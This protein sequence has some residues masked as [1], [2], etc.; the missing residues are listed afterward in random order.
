MPSIILSIKNVPVSF[1]MHPFCGRYSR[2]ALNLQPKICKINGNNV[3]QK[4]KFILNEKDLH[5]ANNY[6][7]GRRS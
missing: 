6:W 2:A 1:E 3:I 5:I 7:R 4:R